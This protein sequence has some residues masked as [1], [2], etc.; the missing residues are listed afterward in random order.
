M[1][2][3]A[4]QFG[5]RFFRTREIPFE[6]RAGQRLTR[7]VEQHARQVVAVEVKARREAALGPQTEQLSGLAAP[8]GLLTAHFHDALRD[9]RLNGVADGLGRQARQAAE[10]RF[11]DRFVQADGFEDDAAVVLMGVLDIR[12]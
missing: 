5:E 9:E 10:L 7:Q 4:Q 6:M 1:I 8:T 12:S 11:G 3:R 2:K